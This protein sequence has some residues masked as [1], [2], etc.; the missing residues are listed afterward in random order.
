MQ[1]WRFALWE[2][3]HLDRVACGER[4]GSFTADVEGIS[5]CFG[6]HQDS[7]MDTVNNIRQLE[8]SVVKRFCECQFCFRV[9]PVVLTILFNVKQ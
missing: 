8:F 9:E 1:G 7:S 2:T 6:I 3:Y 4:R 5:P